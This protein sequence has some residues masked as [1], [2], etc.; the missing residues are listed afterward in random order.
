M[1]TLFMSKPGTCVLVGTF[2]LIVSMLDFIFTLCT[3]ILEGEETSKP[4]ILKDRAAMNNWVTYVTN[5]AC[6][7]F[8]VYMC[9]QTASNITCVIEIKFSQENILISLD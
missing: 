2:N 6:Q 5:S 8:C 4:Y 9:S 3:T 7:F 1:T